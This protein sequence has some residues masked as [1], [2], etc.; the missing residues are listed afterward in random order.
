MVCHLCCIFSL[1]P[2][3]QCS[4][5]VEQEFCI[6]SADSFK[7][8]NLVI[9]SAAALE[10]WKKKKLEEMKNRSIIDETIGMGS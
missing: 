1:N 7:G 5:E 2:P 9:F 3:W 8:C 6:S 4:S 10:E